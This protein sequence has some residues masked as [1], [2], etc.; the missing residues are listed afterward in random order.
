MD[1]GKLFK[2]MSWTLIHA[3]INDS[4][5][6]DHHLEKTGSEAISLIT[7][8]Q[9]CR[10]TNSI[11]F[12]LLYQQKENH[13]SITLQYLSL[14]PDSVMI[15][16]ILHFM[17]C[18]LSRY[19]CILDCPPIKKKCGYLCSDWWICWSWGRIIT[20]SGSFVD[21]ECILALPEKRTALIRH[22]NKNLRKSLTA[23]I[24][25]LPENISD[26]VSVAYL[27]CS[28]QFFLTAW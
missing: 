13:T 19:H 10:C 25:A 8:T 23:S 6:E 7:A 21:K 1:H 15:P 27:S 5:N 26:L 16:I 4:D 20:R 17:P 3:R 2:T 24:S 14:Q 9:K 28:R 18:P 12:P 11:F 22:E